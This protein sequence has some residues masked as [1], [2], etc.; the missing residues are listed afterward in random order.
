MQNTTIRSVILLTQHHHMYNARP[1]KRRR[2]HAPQGQPPSD[3][4]RTTHILPTF[5]HRP[6]F[7][8]QP[9]ILPSG[10]STPPAMVTT[11]TT[12]TT[13]TLITQIPPAVPSS[14]PHVPLPGQ[15]FVPPPSRTFFIGPAEY[16]AR[17]CPS[18]KN[19][20]STSTRLIPSCTGPYGFHLTGTSTCAARDTS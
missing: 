1:S 2:R 18:Q 14:P 13:L 15:P 12:T 7:P 10:W 5:S 20:V 3:R 9:P 6:I 17:T 19:K 11:S 8:P 16:L 4:F